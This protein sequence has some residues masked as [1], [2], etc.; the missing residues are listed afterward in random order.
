MNKEKNDLSRFRK[1][2]KDKYN[3]KHPKH[4]LRYN[5]V[6]RKL[7]KIKEKGELKEIFN[8]L[9]NNFK[10]RFSQEKLFYILFVLRCYNLHL[11]N[12]NHLEPY[13]SKS[14]SLIFI[15]KNC[16]IVKIK[17]EFV[18]IMRDSFDL[19]GLEEKKY[20]KIAEEI[21]KADF[22]ILYDGA[23]FSADSGLQTFEDIQ[24]DKTFSYI[25]LCQ[26]LSNFPELDENHTKNFNDFWGNCFDLYRE[27]TPHDG[28]QILK[29]W[30]K[31]F[32]KKSDKVKSLNSKIRIFDVSM[33]ALHY[34][35]FSLTSNIDS[36]HQKSGLA[37]DRELCEVHGN[38]DSWQCSVKCQPG[39][40]S[41]APSTYKYS[42]KNESDKIT[43]NNNDKI[44][45]ESGNV[46]ICM[47]CN[48]PARPNILMF[49]DNFWYSE[50][51][52]NKYLIWS[53]ALYHLIMDSIEPI[54]IVA[55]EIGCG[56]NVPT[57]R[58]ESENFVEA[59]DH[60]ITERQIIGKETAEQPNKSKITFVRI[61]KFDAN[62]TGLNLSDKDSNSFEYI[63][64]KT[65]ALDSLV[66]IDDHLKDKLKKN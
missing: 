44:K 20:E 41:V 27:T 1:R 14:S 58:K 38:T 5:L 30:K 50:N 15:T 33:P 7:N 4:K 54:R 60:L 13:I 55:L 18:G 56:F 25:T 29:K 17:E 12:K 53:N 66:K 9:D 63:P 64:L 36:H 23:G 48:T 46:P 39:Q 11:K 28:Y 21:S 57:I 49:N 32:F 51:R 59:V 16:S 35:F 61:N 52:G 65:S 45:F 22:L 34:G 2:I 42:P 8:Y 26:P 62:E 37:L 24:R 43:I 10:R 40:F 19:K 47:N 3:E 31:R 6:E